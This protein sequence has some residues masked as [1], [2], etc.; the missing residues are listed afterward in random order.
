MRLSSVISNVSRWC[1]S[2]C[3]TQ[4]QR[5]SVDPFFARSWLAQVEAWKFLA[6]RGGTRTW[7]GD[8]VINSPQ[9]QE[10]IMF[11]ETCS[12]ETRSKLHSVRTSSPGV[13]IEVWQG[14]EAAVSWTARVNKILWDTTVHWLQ[15]RRI[16][17]PNDSL[18]VIQKLERNQNDNHGGKRG[19]T[20]WPSPLRGSH[21]ST[22][23]QCSRSQ[24]QG[25]CFDKFMEQAFLSRWKLLNIIGQTV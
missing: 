16:S 5:Y 12:C 17:V 8:S 14:D 18:L 23:S 6:G 2:C 21:C 19:T 11:F 15:W 3:I 13:V 22:T 4:M 25:E 10:R 20:R 7:V 24:E 1:W 9:K